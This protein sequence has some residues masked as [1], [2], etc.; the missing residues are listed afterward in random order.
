[1]AIDDLTRFTEQQEAMRERMRQVAEQLFDLRTVGVE[2][3]SRLYQRVLE[4]AAV[5]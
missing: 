4:P 2:R 5:V 3:Y 1:M